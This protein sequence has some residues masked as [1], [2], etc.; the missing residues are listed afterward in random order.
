MPA[1]ALQAFLVGPGS[2][3]G[4][5]VA[6]AQAEEHIFGVVLMNDWS[7]RDIQVRVQSAEVVCVCGIAVL[8][9]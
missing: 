4:Q 3:L 2:A 1:R 6:M 8:C 5:P 7:A 9:V